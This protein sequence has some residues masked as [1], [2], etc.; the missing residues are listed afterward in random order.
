MSEVVLYHVSPSFYS[1]IA[2][3]ALCELGVAF[4]ARLA[5]P[6][7]PTFDTYQPWYLALNPMG[8]VPTLVDGERAVPD[9]DAIIRY[10]AEHLS[11]VNLEP[12]DPA[13]LGLMEAW[14]ADLRALSIRE[15]SYGA[16]NKKKA[17]A[18]INRIRLKVL[19]K[20]R[21]KHPD[22]AEV[23]TRKIEDIRGFAERSVD[24]GTV[25]GHIRGVSQK[26]DE[27]DA[28]L[29]D[30]DWITGATYCLADTVWTVAVARFIMLDF[31][32]LNSRPALAEWYAR[33]K[34][35][36]SF[37]QADVWE[38]FRILGMLTMIGRRFRLPLMVGA[39]A[40]SLFILGFCAG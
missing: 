16:E 36:P 38:T 32:P 27:L 40:I 26:L 29:S 15:L 13:L 7:P 30:Q 34:A 24:P 5:A 8:T 9:S 3:L 14:M 25:A 39:G 33:V 18:G 2:R 11:T 22:L 10:A 31:D 28:L 20:R 1:Q 23:Y 4:E 21:E 37:R 6:G 12:E 17:G 35:R 19:A